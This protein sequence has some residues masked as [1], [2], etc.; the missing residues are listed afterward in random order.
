[1]KE[2]VSTSNAAGVFIKVLLILLPLGVVA[3]IPVCTRAYYYHKLGQFDDK[4]TFVLETS[5]KYILFDM[6]P[7]LLISIFIIYLVI[8]KHSIKKL[9][10]ILFAML[11]PTTIFSIIWY[12]KYISGPFAL[13]LLPFINT[14][15]VLIAW[16]WARVLLLKKSQ[17]KLASDSINR[18]GDGSI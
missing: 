13:A 17:A 10:S 9:L 12:L 3:L 14:A 1:M 15:I 2:Q 7:F 18:K 5:L 4:I 8:K 11:L 16:G 6:A